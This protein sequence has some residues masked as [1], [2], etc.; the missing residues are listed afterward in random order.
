[1]E[2]LARPRPSGLSKTC[3]RP[4]VSVCIVNWNCRALLRTCLRSLA[5]YRQGVRLE[6]I[7]VDNASTDGAAAMVAQ[8]FPRV[9]LVRNAANAGFARANNQAVRLARGRYLFFLNNDTVV[10][11]GACAACWPLPE[12]I[13]RRA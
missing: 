4:A 13:P 3:R 9:K 8:E 12:P 6:V 10:P 5:P 1:M 7:V 2:R 11:R